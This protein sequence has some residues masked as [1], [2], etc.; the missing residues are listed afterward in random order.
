MKINSSLTIDKFQDL[1]QNFNFC[2]EFIDQNQ[3]SNSL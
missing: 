2:N 3:D 1:N